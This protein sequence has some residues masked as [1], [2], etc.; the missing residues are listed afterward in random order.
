MKN[1]AK[2]DADTFVFYPSFIRQI[3]AVKRADIRAH[4][5]KAVADYGCF[6]IVPDFSDIDPLG[7]IDGLFEA[8]R[9]VIDESKKKRKELSTM[10]S[11]IGKLGGAPTGNTN[12][13]TKNNQK[14]PNI[15]KTSVNVNGNVD[16]NENVKTTTNVVESIKRASRFTAPSLDEVRR[17]FYENQFSSNPEQFYNHYTANG[18]MIG[19]TKM[20]DWNA[21]AKNWEHRQSEFTQTRTQTPVE[22][23]ETRRADFTNYILNKL[24]T[25]DS[26]EPD[27]S[28]NY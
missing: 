28:D 5:Y 16:V 24:A 26:P 2:H 11:N 21:A 10:R 19:K 22:S 3:E 27:I 20:K 25:P 23:Y 12:A 18:W 7:T 4:I 15:N 13:T 6:N 9:F 17:F 8:I 14:Q 1:N